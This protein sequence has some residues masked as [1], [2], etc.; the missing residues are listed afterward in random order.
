MLT[1]SIHSIKLAQL[2]TNKSEHILIDV[3]SRE[4]RSYTLGQQSEKSAHNFNNDKEYRLRS[5]EREIDLN[6]ITVYFYYP[7]IALYINE[8]IGHL[9]A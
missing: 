4:P 7:D 3:E 6:S 9:L 2:Q 1:Q 8:G 5:V